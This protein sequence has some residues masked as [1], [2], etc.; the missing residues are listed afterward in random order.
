MRHV[1]LLS[2]M[3]CAAGLLLTGAAAGQDAGLDWRSVSASETKIRL[4]DPK[5]DDAGIFLRASTLNYSSTRHIARYP[6][7]KFKLN[8]AYLMYIEV[9]P[10]FY[11]NTTYSPNKILEWKSVK[12]TNPV[13][14]DAFEV[15]TSRGPI[16]VIRFKS[17]GSLDCLALS[18]AWGQS[19]T[20]TTSDG[21]DLLIGYI[22]AETFKSFS[23]ADFE[24]LRKLIRVRD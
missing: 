14:G 10:G 24:F 2:T 1:A 16:Q 20:E 3:I 9:L 12:A 18:Q 23:R 19:G 5:L 21:T 8:A 11:L 4:N 22:C 6:T 7:S 15:T 13:P 17:E